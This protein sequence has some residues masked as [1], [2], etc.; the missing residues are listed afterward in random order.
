MGGLPTLL[1]KIG[2]LVS[3][4][5][6]SNNNHQKSNRES[7]ITAHGRS[8]S[9]TGPNLPKIPQDTKHDTENFSSTES[10]VN[11][12]LYESAEYIYESFGI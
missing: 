3:N 6:I 11:Q 8:K 2:T 9:D 5:L 12:Y 4:S 7:A 10:L 1:P